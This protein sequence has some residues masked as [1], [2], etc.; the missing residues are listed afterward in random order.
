MDFGFEV[1][2]ASVVAVVAV[3]VVLAV[4]AVLVVVFCR[5]FCCSSICRCCRC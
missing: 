5:G 4:V 3:V 2:P 1:I